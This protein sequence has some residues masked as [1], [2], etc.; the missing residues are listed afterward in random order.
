MLGQFLQTGKD[1]YGVKL[2][3]VFR[4]F[5]DYKLPGYVYATV[6][7]EK[8]FGLNAF[9][10]RLSSALLGSLA[11]L[12]MYFLIKEIFDSQSR[13]VDKKFS[14]QIALLTSFML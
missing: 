2:P 12:V 3:L 1:E 6:I 5:E 10:V 11:V 9:A 13:I 14:T 7:S 4:S 8:L